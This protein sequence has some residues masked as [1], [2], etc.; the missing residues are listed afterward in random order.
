M[1]HSKPL[2]NIN[3]LNFEG[4]PSLLN[5]FFDQIRSYASINKLKPDETVAFL[6]GKLSGPA[7][8]FM[9]QSPILYKSNDLN[10]IESEFKS[11]FTPMS[12][13]QALVEFN[14]LVMLPQETIK[15]LSHRLN[16]LADIIY[17]R[18]TDPT[19]LDQIKFT[20]FISVIPSN[21][22]IKL[23]EEN[24]NDYKTGIQRAQVLQEINVNEKILTNQASNPVLTNLSERVLHLTEKLDAFTFANS[25][26]DKEDSSV[27]TKTQSRFNHNK[28]KNNFKSRQM[29]MQDNQF[30]NSKNRT[31]SVICQL[32][33]RPGHT[34]IKCFK[35]Q[36]INSRKNNN[37]RNNFDTQRLNQRRDNLNLN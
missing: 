24:I 31:S 4:D 23:Q 36:R 30:Q 13:T 16:I 7:L 21:I 1:S 20:K 11:F 9:T 34:A 5:F 32:C 25:K 3:V 19:A 17:S 29:R 37:S 8:K 33:S 22:R 14:N 26:E 15:N 27:K 35:W 2:V 28:F 12:S 6:K 18:I 10:F